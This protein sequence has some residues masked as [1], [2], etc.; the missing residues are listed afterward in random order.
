MGSVK[1]MSWIEVLFS[2]KGR[3][4]RRTYWLA[5]LGGTLLF[6]FVVFGAIAV[7]GGVEPGEDNPIQIAVTLVAM[8]PY[9]WMTFAIQAKRWHDRDKSLVWMLIA[10]VPLIG[11]IWVFIE[12]GLLEGTPGPNPYGPDPKGRA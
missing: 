2:F 10:F 12:C 11:G 1:P 7:T 9:T 3:I 8:M 4:R 6:Y 5:S